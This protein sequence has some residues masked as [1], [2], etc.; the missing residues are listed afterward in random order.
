MIARLWCGCVHI[1]FLALAGPFTLHVPNMINCNCRVPC[2]LALLT[3]LC[4]STL[5]CTAAVVLLYRS[6]LNG[7]FIC[8]H[9]MPFIKRHAHYLKHRPTMITR[10]GIHIIVILIV[11]FAVVQVVNLSFS[12]ISRQQTN[13][14]I[15]A[16]DAHCHTQ[17]VKWRKDTITRWDSKLDL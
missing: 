1:R 13:I 5:N 8:L 14:E 3:T 4:L 11:T 16:G 6:N 7:L 15:V 2:V 9:A 17:S 12:V 10:V